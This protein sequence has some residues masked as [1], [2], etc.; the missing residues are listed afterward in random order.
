MENTI[1]PITEIKGPTIIGPTFTVDGFEF[2]L[3]VADAKTHYI[4]GIDVINLLMVALASTEDKK[5][6]KI[7]RDAKIEIKDVSGK[8]YF[9]K[10]QD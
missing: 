1:K 3:P 4:S 9:P 5:V 6:R 2:P 10:E 8:I 7:L